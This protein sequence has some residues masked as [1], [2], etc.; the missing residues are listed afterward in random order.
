MHLQTAMKV[1]K[2]Y[3]KSKHRNHGSE[4]SRV[5]SYKASTF[6]AVNSKLIVA[7]AVLLLV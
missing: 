7:Y 6:K 5:P 2:N 4:N 3:H 1:S